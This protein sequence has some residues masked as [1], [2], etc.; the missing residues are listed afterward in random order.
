MTKEDKGR[1][2]GSKM[3]SFS[4]ESTDGNV[5]T[6]DQL[7]GRPVLIYFMRGTW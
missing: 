3:P 7:K 6:D 2:K 5:Y 4:L 1:T